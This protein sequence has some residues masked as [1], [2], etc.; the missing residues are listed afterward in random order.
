MRTLPDLINY[1]SIDGT[2]GTLAG[3]PRDG[4]VTPAEFKNFWSSL[5][6]AEKEYY[7]T[8]SIG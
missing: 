8:A 2:I 3:N 5:S 1:F 4:K 7:K 6:D